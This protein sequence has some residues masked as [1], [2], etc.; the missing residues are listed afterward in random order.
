MIPCVLKFAGNVPPIVVFG[1]GLTGIS[2]WRT[3]EMVGVMLGD[4]LIW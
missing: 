1:G 3:R 2:S 4:Q